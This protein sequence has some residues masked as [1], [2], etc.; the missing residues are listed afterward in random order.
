MFKK[1][2]KKTEEVAKKTVDARKKVGEKEGH[3][4]Y[5]NSQLKTYTNMHASNLMAIS[6]AD[7]PLFPH[8]RQVE[9]VCLYVQLEKCHA[10]AEANRA[11][12]VY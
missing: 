11:S 4:I 8:A 12:S 2:K 5:P 10:R 3:K 7:S 1:L 6:P 9:P